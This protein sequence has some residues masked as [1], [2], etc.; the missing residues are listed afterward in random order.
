V[1]YAN[2]F[3]QEQSPKYH[4]QVETLLPELPTDFSNPDPNLKNRLEV[5]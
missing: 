2:K 3:H 1:G 5:I 4:L